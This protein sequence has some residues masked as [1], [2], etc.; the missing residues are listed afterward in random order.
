L[1]RF[2]IPAMDVLA[3][4]LLLV[5]TA[6]DARPDVVAFAGAVLCLLA[7]SGLQR[8]KLELSLLDDLPLLLLIGLAAAGVSLSLSAIGGP[9]GQPRL[10]GSIALGLLLV[11][12]ARS[13]SYALTRRARRYDRYS[14]PTLIIGCGEIG[15]RI[16]LTMRDKPHYGLNF[17]G[18]LDDDPLLP[19]QDR[20]GPLLGNANELNS[21]IRL[22]HVENV[23]VAFSGSS[24]LD[25]IEVLRTCDRMGVEIFIVPR[26]FE[27]QASGPGTD[28]LS[29]LPLTRL[30][31][32]AFRS[33][34]WPL[35]R[36][37]DVL[38]AIAAG[39]LLLP[40]IALCAAATRLEGGRGILFRQTRIG[41]D[42]A[43]FSILKFRSMR[44]GSDK[45]AQTNWNISCDRR[46]GPVGRLMRRLSLD[47]LPQLWN[48]L[49]GDMSLVGPRPERPHFVSLF[50]GEFRE[51]L[52]RHRV[53]CGLTGWAQVNG[54]RGDTS[55]EDRVRYDNYYIENWSLWLDVKIIL[56][57][58]GQV[59]RMAGS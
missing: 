17:V 32:P 8:P 4:A 34:T 55:I 54:L 37:L 3:L 35:K 58:V 6:S 30:R 16:A 33:R 46:V 39:T 25:M 5:L 41:L 49:V 12:M 13:A 52:H 51:Y 26:L 24:S 31:R 43:E 27:V 38:V 53:P 47:E 2:L 22:H 44:P 1:T 45:E 15:A 42:G 20:P 56:R 14:S 7:A 9:G 29:G 48:I 36:G 57:T 11:L 23:I 28:S 21:L 50:E 19:S 10:L 59:V 18:F 40:I